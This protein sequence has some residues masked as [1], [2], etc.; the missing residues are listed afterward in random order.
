MN[1][2]VGPVVIGAVHDLERACDAID[3]LNHLPAT[4]NGDVAFELGEAS[5]AAHRALLVL[6]TW[7]WAPSSGIAAAP[8]SAADAS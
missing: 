7:D 8:S 6:R 1:V 3:S 5:Q 2:S 4:W